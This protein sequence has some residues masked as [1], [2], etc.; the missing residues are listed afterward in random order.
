MFYVVAIAGVD[1]SKIKQLLDQLT[2]ALKF[3]E[4]NSA[5]LRKGIYFLAAVACLNLPSSLDASAVAAAAAAASGVGSSSVGVGSTAAAAVAEDPGSS[6]K[7][8][9]AKHNK[10]E[11]VVVAAAA[12]GVAEPEQQAVEQALQLA[13]GIQPQLPQLIR[14][15]CGARLITLLHSLQHRTGQ[16]QQQQHKGKQQQQQAGSE[17]TATATAAAGESKKQKRSR[18]QQ[19]QEQAAAA[20]RTAATQQH[21]ALTSQI[22]AFVMTALQQDGVQPMADEDVV[23]MVQQLHQ[24]ETAVGQHTKQQQQQQGGGS[25]AAATSSSVRS[26]ACIQ[27]IQQLQL[28][29]LSGGLTAEAAGS[30]V[31]DLEVAV[32]LCL[33]MPDND[34]GVDR[35]ASDLIRSDNEGSDSQRDSEDDESSDA[36]EDDPAWQDVLLDLL[37]ALLSSSSD[38][39]AAKAGGVLVPTAPLREACEA[40]FRAFAEDITAQGGSLRP[41]C[42]GHAIILTIAALM[43]F[44]FIVLSGC[45]LPVGPHTKDLKLIDGLQHGV[46]ACKDWASCT[47]CYHWHVC[48]AF[49][50]ICCTSTSTAIS[51]QPQPSS[52]TDV[53]VASSR[54]LHCIQVQGPGSAS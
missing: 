40:V 10:G 1:D 22:L 45:Y 3:P 49:R 2:A 51:Q 33:G 34:L 31:D 9:K 37:L 52:N 21:E 43:V 17:F 39:A 11:K 28:Q 18:E 6:K 26:K 46:N 25:A 35:S 47:D 29:L 15:Y 20:A 50:C 36:D 8:K 27:L 19:E 24:L 14:Q 32:V 4:A 42:L 41:N 23:E 38:A 54:S 48:C 12:G 53:P 13:G 5:T 30:V 7:A 44:C 16:Q